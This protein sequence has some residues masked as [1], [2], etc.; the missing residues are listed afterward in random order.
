M[1]AVA[2][3]AGLVFLVWRASGPLAT[4]AVTV[5]GASLVLLYAAST[6]HHAIPPT[7]GRRHVLRR[8]DH[9]S[10]YLLIMG[11]YAPPCLLVLPRN[12][13]IPILAIVWTAGLVGIALKVFRPFT[14]RWATVALYI[15]MGWAVVAAIPFAWQ[16]L[17]GPG[18]WLLMGGGIVYTLGAVVYALQK[19]DPWPRHLGFH[20]VWH[21]MVIVASV[22]HFVFIAL[23]VPLG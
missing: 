3:L 10:I 13:G 23:Y 2:A 18:V 7:P 17:A 16:A 11:T 9:V 15:A 5:Y 1:G 4:A 20:G 14:G 12:V 19:P 22:L 6:L 21:V 8:L